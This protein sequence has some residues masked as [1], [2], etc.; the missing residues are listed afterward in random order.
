MMVL[1]RSFTSLRLGVVL[2]DFFLRSLREMSR[3]FPNVQVF[4]VDIDLD[5]LGSTLSK[6]EIY[7]VPTLHFFQNGKKVGTVVGADV[8]QVKGKMVDL[9]K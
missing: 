3:E 8:E 2:V 6:F 9:Y 7:S 4:K 5:G 1:T